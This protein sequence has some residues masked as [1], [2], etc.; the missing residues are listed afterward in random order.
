VSGV[1]GFGS[2]L[3]YLGYGYLDTWHGLATLVLLPIFLVGLV[4]SLLALRPLA[5]PS[6]A[7]EIQ[8]GSPAP[9]SPAYRLGRFLLLATSASLV[10]GGLIIMAVGMTSVFVPQDLEFIGL[11]AAELAEVSPRLIPLIAHDRAGF[12]GGVCCCGV[13]MFLCAWRGQ[14][15]RSLWQSLLIAGTAGFGSAVG[16]HFPIGYTSFIHLAPA[17]VG[18]A[19]FCLGMLLT[20]REMLN[21]RNAPEPCLRLCNENA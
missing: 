11:T 18:A 5:G 3:A 15:S 12:G 21:P 17:Y 1:I 7:F 14:P 4:E 10:L 19:I 2:F 9:C 16:V 8:R 6:A 13:T 20:C